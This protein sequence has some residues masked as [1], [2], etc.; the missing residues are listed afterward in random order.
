MKRVLLVLLWISCAPALAE[1]LKT[2]LLQAWENL[3]AKS[4]EVAEFRKLAE[5]KYWIKFVTLPYEG[6]LLVLAYDTEDFSL[7]MT[8]I[9]YTKLGYVEVDLVDASS[10]E[11]AKY[12]RTHSKWAQNNTF[13][14]NQESGAWEGFAEYRERLEQETED[15]APSS[16]I[17]TLF[18]N[19]HILLLAILLYFVYVAFA[20][21]R[22]VKK[23]M[24]LQQKAMAD[25]DITTRYMKESMQLQKE[26]NAL[27]EQIL[28]E[29]KKRSE[30][31][32][33]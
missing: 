21:D 14:Y 15:L 22:R 23:S 9:P 10:E 8:E 13:Y 2:S 4:A 30:Q 24:A 16:W 25:F 5:R 11:I 12:A 31:E 6:E 29:L 1:D 18:E 19:G 3:Q 20:S 32:E 17:L 28:E 27:L 7:G 33:R 26:A